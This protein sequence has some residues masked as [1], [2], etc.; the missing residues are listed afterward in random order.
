[1][2]SLDPDEPY[3]IVFIDAQ[4]SG[5]PRYLEAVLQKS[6][7]GACYRLLRPGGLIIGDNALRSAL[8]A[9][10]SDANPATQTVPRETENWNWDD[11]KFLDEFNRNMN[12]NPRLETFLLP[13]FDGLGI[14]RL[15][16]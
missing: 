3:D 9:D 1:V 16:D 8:V 14:A 11:V 13:V 10:Q 12:T 6:L 2:G 7:P 15:L 4:K 5:Y